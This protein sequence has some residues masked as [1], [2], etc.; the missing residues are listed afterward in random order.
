MCGVV[1]FAARDVPDSF[2]ICHCENCRRWTGVA[3]LSVSLARASIDWT[4]AE[5]IRTIQSSPWAERAWCGQC[6][7]GLYYRPT[8]AKSDAEERLVMGLGLFDEPSGFTLENQ[9]FIDCKPDSYAFAGDHPRLTRAEV[10][11]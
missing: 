1:S 11:Q 10:M 7:S 3:T 8:D 4:G 2:G 6:G 5:E 9:I